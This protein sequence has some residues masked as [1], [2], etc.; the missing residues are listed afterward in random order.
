MHHGGGN[1][2]QPFGCLNIYR[3]AFRARRKNERKTKRN[4][5][6]KRAG[7][8]RARGWSEMHRRIG[9]EG[10]EERNEYT[11]RRGEGKNGTIKTNFSDKEVN[12]PVEIGR[13]WELANDRNGRAR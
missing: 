12:G 5:Q 3:A 7:E 4:Q 10:G 11:H 1:S 6:K 2:Y 13:R 9:G 8:G